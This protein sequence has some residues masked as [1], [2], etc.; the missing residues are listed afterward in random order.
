M[1]ASAS[2]QCFKYGSDGPFVLSSTCEESQ[3]ISDI[4]T[5]SYWAALFTLMLNSK[6]AKGRIS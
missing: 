6:N 5:P 3:V 2:S 1:G 4:N